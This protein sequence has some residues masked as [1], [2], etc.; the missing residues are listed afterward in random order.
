MSRK[1]TI[2]PQCGQ[3]ITRKPGAGGRPPKVHPGGLRA[4]RAAKKQAAR[5]RNDPLYGSAIR[6]ESSRRAWNAKLMRG[7]QKSVRPELGRSGIMGSAMLPETGAAKD[8]SWKA[9]PD[10]KTKAGI[11][12]KID[13]GGQID[14]LQL[15]WVDGRLVPVHYD[16]YDFD[17]LSPDEI[18]IIVYK[19]ALA[20]D[21]TTAFAAQAFIEGWQLHGKSTALRILEEMIE[22]GPAAAIEMRLQDELA[23]AR[24]AGLRLYDQRPDARIIERLVQLGRYQSA[25]LAASGGKAA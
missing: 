15:G 20:A 9:K 16:E 7:W 24:R 10:A 3:P 8:D 5:K 1:N 23:R 19:A 12:G 4:G 14:T 2:C 18:R 17:A 25:A 22:D 21:S 13:R 11:T 6:K